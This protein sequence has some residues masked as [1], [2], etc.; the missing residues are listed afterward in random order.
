MPAG[1]AIRVKGAAVAAEVGWA[2]VQRLGAGA[3][4]A[5]R[6]GGDAGDDGSSA[7]RGPCGRGRGRD[8]LLRG[9]AERRGA[10][11]VVGGAGAANA[12][13]FRLVG[14]VEVAVAVVVAAALAV[15]NVEA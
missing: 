2:E 5:S 1:F 9:A 7:G 6:Q 13:A 3:L 14:R 4:A 15:A 11:W 12:A 8:G 10:A